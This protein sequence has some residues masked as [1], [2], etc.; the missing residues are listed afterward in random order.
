M[1]IVLVTSKET[2][3]SATEIVT[4]GLL[5]FGTLLSP[6]LFIGFIVWQGVEKGIS[7]RRDRKQQLL[8]SSLPCQNCHYFSACEA[9]PCAVNP[10]QV[11]TAEARS[12]R[13]FFPQKHY[14]SPAVMERSA[15]VRRS[16]DR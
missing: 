1:C 9:L 15:K 5:L 8:Y 3:V 10:E 11:L 12:C 6:I 16:S 13:D 2:V 4:N 7:V 14:S